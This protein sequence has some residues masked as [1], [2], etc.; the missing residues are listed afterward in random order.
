MTRRDQWHKRP[1]VERYW[2]YKGQIR[3]SLSS[4]PESGLHVLFILPMPKSWSK[5]K[6][7]MMD[8]QPHRQRPDIDNLHKGLLDAVFDDDCA[9]WDHRLTKLWGEEG[10]ICLKRIQ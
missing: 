4:L 3:V 5:K 1:I 10:A 6:R 9:V 8:G 2:A 7:A